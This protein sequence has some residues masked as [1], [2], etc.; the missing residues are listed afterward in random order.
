RLLIPLTAGGLVI[1]RR[2][3]NIAALLAASGAKV[4][5]GQK[6][7]VKVHE[8]LVTVQGK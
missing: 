1:G 4:T 3:A 8:R 6:A 7:D 2:G 5:L